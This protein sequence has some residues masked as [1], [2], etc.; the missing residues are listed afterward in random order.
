LEGGPPRFSPR[1]TGADL[2]RNSCDSPSDFVY[3][4]IALYG[5][6]FHALP[7]SLGLVTAAGSVTT[8]TSCPTTPHAQRVTAYTHTV[9]ADPFSL[10]TTQG[11]SVDLLSSGY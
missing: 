3:G 1:F 5:A 4:T 7:L 10:A 11:V 2:L 8:R 9:W 6:R